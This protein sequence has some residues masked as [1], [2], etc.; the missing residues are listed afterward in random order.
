VLKE[1]ASSGWRVIGAALI[2]LLASG[3]AA[4]DPIAESHIVGNV[5][6][7]ADFDRL[8]RRDLQAYFAIL[9]HGGRLDF[10]LLRKSPTQSGIAYPKYYVWVSLYE[11]RTD[12][13]LVEGSARVA[14]IDRVRFEVTDFLNKADILQRPGAIEAIFPGPVCEE[15]RKRL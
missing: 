9:G 10:S 1:A 11:E 14:A 13:L 6:V 2:C 3:L 12:R 4:C 5:P 15:I 8:L 7:S